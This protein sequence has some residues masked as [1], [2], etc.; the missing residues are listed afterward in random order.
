MA[1]KYFDSSTSAVGKVLTFFDT[2]SVVVTGV[3]QNMPDN[4]HLQADFL[5]SMKTVEPMYPQWV[6]DNRTGT[7][8]YTYV[9]L[10]EGADPERLADQI[11]QYILEYGGVSRRPSSVVISYK[12][13]PTFTSGHS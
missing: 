13:S 12:P 7:S 8:H 11:N 4:S 5:V 3:M 1:N 10:A 2:L 6:L 9:R